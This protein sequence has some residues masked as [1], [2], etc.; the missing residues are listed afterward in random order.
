M[1]DA[2]P[3]EPGGPTLAAPGHDGCA[4]ERAAVRAGC[5]DAART[6]LAHEGAVE[7]LRE[8]RRSLAAVRHAEEAARIVAE[9]AKEAC[10]QARVL[11]ARCEEEMEAAARMSADH[12]VEAAQLVLVAAG[13]GLRPETGG[14]R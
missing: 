9:P 14:A 6:Q 1:S 7:A 11:L 10:L 3:S 8:A 4:P 5:D 2:P 13:D 12:P